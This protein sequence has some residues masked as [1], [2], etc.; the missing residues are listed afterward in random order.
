MMR[1]GIRHASCRVKAIQ[2][3][4][5]AATVSAAPLTNMPD[6][7]Y[8][9]ISHRCF[10]IENRV[11]RCSNTR[12]FARITTRKSSLGPDSSRLCRR[13]SRPLRPDCPPKACITLCT[14]LDSGSES[15]TLMSAHFLISA[16]PYPSGVVKARRAHEV[17]FSILFHS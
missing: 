9:R 7:L 3:R 14:T 8:A 11:T 13:P 2:S 4:S 5:H 16:R 1:S 15:M 6:V 10:R 12:A 17:G